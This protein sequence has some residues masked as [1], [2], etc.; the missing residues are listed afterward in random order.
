MTYCLYVYCALGQKRSKSNKMILLRREPTSTNY[1][2]HPSSIAD[3]WLHA[4]YFYKISFNGNLYSNLF[5]DGVRIMAYGNQ[6][7]EKGFG[8]W[9]Y[10]ALISLRHT[11]MKT[12]SSAAGKPL[13]EKR[14]DRTFTA[15]A[16]RLCPFLVRSS[17]I[18]S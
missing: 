8:V 18:D 17:P 4:K 6:V 11:K 5:F 3:N 16:S 13:N 12:Q 2:V 9:P 15:L 14:T 10:L 1:F 7:C